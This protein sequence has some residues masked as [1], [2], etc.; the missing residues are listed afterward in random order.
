[1]MA[2]RL[3]ANNLRTYYQLSMLENMDQWWHWMLLA[4]ICLAIVAYVAVLYRR[5]SVDLS[6]GKRWLLCLLR[7]AAFVG[8]LVFFLDLEKRSER[9]IVINSRLIM[10][11][12]TSQSMGLPSSDA[13]GS[14]NRIEEIVSELRDGDWLKELRRKHDLI[15]YRFDATERPAEIASLLQL[16]SAEGEVANEAAPDGS[17]LREARILFLISSGILCI[18]LLALLIHLFFRKWVLGDEGQSWAL[19]VSGVSAMI[20]MIIL[21]VANLRNPEIGPPQI[22]GLAEAQAASDLSPAA[23][24]Q[25]DANVDS[26][27]ALPKE[28]RWTEVLNP[29][30]TE[31]RLGDALQF[32]L[33]KERGGPVAGVVLVTDGRGNSGVDY[34]EAVQVAMD[35]GIPV[36]PIGLG[37]EKRP[38]NVRVV[39]VETPP[40]IYPGDRFTV[41]GYLQA[42]GLEGRSVKVELFSGEVGA[43]PQTDSVDRFESEQRVRLSAKGQ[44]IPIEF[45]VIPNETGRRRYTIRVTP[46]REDGDASD[47]EKSSVVE[48]VDRKNRVLLF[49]GGPTREYRFLRNQLYRDR[50]VSSDVLLQTSKLGASQ[51]ADN[52]L[53]EFPAT[54]REM[55]E[56]D[57]LIAFDPDWTQLDDRQIETL[58]RWVSQ[59]AGGIIAIAGSVYTPR[60]TARRVGDSRLEKIRALYPVTFYSRAGSSLAG[61]NFGSESAW[62]LRF[63]ED[64]MRAR[65][66]WLE[67][68]ALLSEQAWSEFDGIYGYYSTRGP[69][70][71][72]TVYARFSDPRTAIDDEL[73]AYLAG[74]FYGA[75]RVFFQASGEMWRLRA[76]NEAYFEQYYTKLI[77]YVSEGRLLRD[78]DRGVLLVDKDR[79]LLGDTVTIR[80]ALTDSQFQP[81]DVPQVDAT[82]VDP[83]GERFPVMLR[84]VHESSAGGMYSGQFTAV[85][86][87]DY[88]LELIIPGASLEDV[89]T[90]HVRVRVPALEIE[91]PERD[92]AVLSDIAGRT[93]GTYYV[94]MDAA[95]GR[96]GLA[97]LA[98]VIAPQEQV[99]YFPGIPDRDFERRLMS[100]LIALICGT[101]CLEWLIRR[102]NK[103]A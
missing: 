74:Q 99:T 67:D 1:M 28:P 102:L 19:L 34:T 40:R 78:S 53:T 2:G 90:R 75:G 13:E 38:A 14:S 48:V 22:L 72:A 97:S 26:E 100:W 10:L 15:I 27:G 5:D 17:S 64:G 23:D 33:Q 30:G 46:P 94:G 45:E 85:L 41:K 9:R 59:Q 16:R 80:A 52:L 95:L 86:E 31:T 25:Q 51:E 88:R 81:L 82:V 77:R 18:A 83:R 3:P 36:Y 44:V 42:T 37:S 7:V 20:A 12:D 91:R 60:W 21:A 93:G 66:L 62:P 71:G 65:F 63:T 4:S 61:T 49:A 68:T 39:D 54:K 11:V 57:C 103:L 101:L 32:V 29:R 70:P 50:E 98:N 73:P 56:Y 24:E 58:E 47:D 79:C 55:F 69:K 84:Q 43:D 76:V 8:L 92:D 6:I 89:L 96:R 35:T 87:G